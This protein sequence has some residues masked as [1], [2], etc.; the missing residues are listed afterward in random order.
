[1]ASIFTKII[2]GELPAR[3]IYK[4]DVVVS[5]LTVNPVA[6]GHVLVVPIEEVDHWVDLEQ[7]T[8]DHIMKV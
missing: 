2:D 6:P 8:I 7:S 3:F 5:F 4:D 1:M